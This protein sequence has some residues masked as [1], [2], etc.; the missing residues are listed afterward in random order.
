MI[1]IPLAD[2]VSGRGEG[3]STTTRTLCVLDCAGFTCK[4]TA[5]RFAISASIT[6]SG[7][8]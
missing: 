6:F 7:S 5:K 2:G 8:V 3:T 4:V 1:S